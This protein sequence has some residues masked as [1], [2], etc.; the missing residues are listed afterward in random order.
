MTSGLTTEALPGERASAPTSN[1]TTVQVRDGKVLISG[2]R[3]AENRRS[4]DDSYLRRRPASEVQTPSAI[5]S[6][7]SGHLDPAVRLRP[8]TT[9]PDELSPNLPLPDSGRLAR[10]GGVCSERNLKLI[11]SPRFRDEIIPLVP[12][13]STAALEM[14][15][16]FH[17][18]Q[19]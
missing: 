8:A 1:A 6:W 10:D 5:P 16:H 19:T 2:G 15:A 18:V 12:K 9:I 13:R 4:L 17:P 11:Q 14:A 3:F 7:T